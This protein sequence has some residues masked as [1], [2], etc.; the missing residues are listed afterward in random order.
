MAVG[1]HGQALS[2]T[3]LRPKSIP[4]YPL[5]LLGH[6]CPVPRDSAVHGRLGTE[7]PA[8]RLLHRRPGL[9][10][11]WN[12]S[13]LT[14]AD[15]LFACRPLIIDRDNCPDPDLGLHVPS[16]L[17]APRERRQPL[18]CR[19]LNPDPEAMQEARAILEAVQSLSGSHPHLDS[20]DWDGFSTNF[21][22]LAD[23]HLDFPNPRRDINNRPRSQLAREVTSQAAIPIL[24]HLSDLRVHCSVA[25]KQEHSGA[26]LLIQSTGADRLRAADYR[27]TTGTSDLALPLPV[28][29]R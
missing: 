13:R 2:G 28:A 26:F 14:P 25:S 7:S 23:V 1:P 9:S 6:H 20:A 5:S 8:P 18:D 21:T 11:D 19:T 4:D 27:A 17:S 10:L 22:R 29:E 12:W 24:V 15:F 3:R 16:E